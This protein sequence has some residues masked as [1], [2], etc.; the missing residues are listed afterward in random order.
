ME[1]FLTKLC[2][3]TLQG[4]EIE[5]AAAFGGSGVSLCIYVMSCSNL[6]LTLS[7]SGGTRF[8]LYKSV[9]FFLLGLISK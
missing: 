2:L 9:S 3:I 8:K 4:K 6:L 1:P 5:S 7:P